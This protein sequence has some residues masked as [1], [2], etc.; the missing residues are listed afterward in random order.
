MHTDTY[1]HTHTHTHIYTMQVKLKLEGDKDT[2]ERRLR[3]LI[4]L[5]NAQSG[6][7]EDSILTLDEC[8]DRINAQDKGRR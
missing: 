4:H 2:L 5:L 7:G 3:E 1:K 8:I 6:Q